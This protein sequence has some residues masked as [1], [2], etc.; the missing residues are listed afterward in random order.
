MGVEINYERADSRVLR[1]E[2]ELP[3]LATKEDLANVQMCLQKMETRLV[4]WV[5]VALGIAVTVVTAIAGAVVGIVA[6]FS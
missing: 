6:A 3:H 1:L 2:T 4:K 5:V